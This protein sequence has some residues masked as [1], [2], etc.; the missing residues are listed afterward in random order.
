VHL[1]HLIPSMAFAF[2]E[3]F[4]INIKKDALLKYG[5]MAGRWLSELKKHIREGKA[6]DFE[7]KAESEDGKK[8]FTL[9]E[10]KDNIVLIS[11]GQKIVY[12]VDAVYS[13]ENTEK[14]ISLA[15]GADVFYCEATFL[16][17]DIE[18]AKDRYHL[19]ARQAG[20]LARRAG[21]KRLEIFHFSPRYNYRE[22]L[23]YREAM[24]EFGKA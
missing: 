22:E 20:E 11:K 17:E 7:I 6:D 1:D 5:L 9:K 24:A 4:H 3:D 10:L 14:I 18:R 12:V 8:T 2:S 15:E 21:V 19:T 13:K 16:E 23:L